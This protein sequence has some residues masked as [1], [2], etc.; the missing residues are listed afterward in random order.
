MINV[1]NVI[2]KIVIKLIFNIVGLLLVILGQGIIILASVSSIL[3]NILTAIIFFGAI[4][5]TFS[6]LPLSNKI[7]FWVLAIISGAIAT[8]IYA[9]PLYL[10]NTGRYLMDFDFN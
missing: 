6:D 5:L 2:M 7:F 8:N 3:M 9:L 4:V 1:L 10:V